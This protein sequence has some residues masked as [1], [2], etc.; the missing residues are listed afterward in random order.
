M[1]LG[2]RYRT[3]VDGGTRA[4]WG[5]FVRTTFGID[6]TVM[7]IQRRLHIRHT[8]HAAALQTAQRTG[9]WPHIRQ[10]VISEGVLFAIQR[11]W[12]LLT[13]AFTLQEYE[14]N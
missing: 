12:R 2:P 10:K 11:K 5:I 13:I 6:L 1:G 9:R 14:N 4:R 7:L 8:G 3:F